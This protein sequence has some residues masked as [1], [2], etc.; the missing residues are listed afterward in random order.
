LNERALQ[1]EAPTA[2][3]PVTNQ[4]IGT[5]AELIGYQLDADNIVA[6][7]PFDVTLYWRV[8]QTADTPHT[9]FTH[10][11]AENGTLIAQHDAPP[12]RPVT[13]WVAGEIITNKHTLTFNTP[14]HSGTASLVVG[15]YDSTTVVRVNTEQG[16]SQIVL[17]ELN[18]R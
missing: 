14:D 13:N 2:I 5:M 12:T 18:I 6:G 4:Q 1:W 7:Q 11:L 8:L 9:I 3:Q 15:M 16:D 17:S 10:L